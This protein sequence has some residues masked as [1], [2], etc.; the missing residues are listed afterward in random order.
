MEK[1]ERIGVLIMQLV[2]LFLLFETL[3]FG[4]IGAML[5]VGFGVIGKIMISFGVMVMTLVPAII[6]FFNETLRYRILKYTQG[7]L[8]T[9]LFSLLF[10]QAVFVLIGMGVGEFNIELGR[11]LNPMVQMIMM[12]MYIGSILF[13]PYNYVK[14]IISEVKGNEFRRPKMIMKQYKE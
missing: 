13:M 14:H 1:L 6:T 3:K 5:G 10:F 8:T 12:M 4:T 2:M 7:N 9:Y 11:D